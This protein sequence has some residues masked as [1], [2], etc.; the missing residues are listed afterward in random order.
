MTLELHLIYA[1]QLEDLPGIIGRCCLQTQFL[2]GTLATEWR[3][4]GS[5]IN[6][7]GSHGFHNVFGVNSAGQAVGDS[8]LVGGDVTATEWRS[9]GSVINLGGLPRSTFSEANS[10]NDEGE[11]VGFSTGSLFVPE[12]STWAMMLVGFAS[13]AL[14]G[15]RRAK[16][17]DAKV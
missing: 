16:A 1:L 9:D 13:L 4:D 5:V 3:S 7:G 2:G 10:I 17:G 6:L 15:Y 12:S 8:S 11:A 14:A